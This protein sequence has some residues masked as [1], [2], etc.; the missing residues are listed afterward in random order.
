MFGE[1]TYNVL[2]ICDYIIRRCNELEY[3]VNYYKLCHYLYFSKALFVSRYNRTLF[4]EKMYACDFGV[5]IPEVAHALGHYYN[6]Y[7]PDNYSL[8]FLFGGERTSPAKIRKEDSEKI[9][10]VINLFRYHLMSDMC[11]IIQNQKP[12]KAAYLNKLT[13]GM[14]CPCAEITDRA[15]RSYFREEQE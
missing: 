6:S 3:F 2:D 7:I 15:F 13:E 1:K 5:V 4:K 9:D 14:F 12:W 10:E 11:S 8:V